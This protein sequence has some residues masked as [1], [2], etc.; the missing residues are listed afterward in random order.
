MAHG[1]GRGLLIKEQ[2][3]GAGVDSGERSK[4]YDYDAAGN[5]SLFID[6]IGRR[7]EYEYDAMNRRKKIT[8][9]LN[10]QPQVVTVDYSKSGVVKKVTNPSGVQNFG[11]DEDGNPIKVDS[12]PPTDLSPDSPLFAP[13]A[14]TSSKR[15]GVGNITTETDALGRTTTHTYDAFGHVLTTTNALGEVTRFSYDKAGNLLTVT[16]PPR[17]YHLPQLRRSQPAPQRNRPS[18]RRDSVHL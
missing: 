14:S 15:D 6:G 3:T 10:G 17:V 1:N 11:S 18:G 9:V 7:T 16:D 12:A 5:L 4:S 8:T 2:V 13:Q